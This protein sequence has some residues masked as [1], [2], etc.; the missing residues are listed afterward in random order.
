MKLYYHPLSGYSMKA[1]LALNETD[2][3]FEREIINLMDPESRKSFREVYPLGKVP[4]L[5]LD[6]GHQ[7]PESSIIV[8]WIDQK[9]KTDLIPQDPDLARQA[10]FFDRMSD[11][12]LNNQVGTIFFDTMRPENERNP[13]AVAQAKETLSYLYKKYDKALE[14]KDYLVG[15]F[16]IADLSTFSGLFWAQKVFPYSEYSNLS[17]YFNR[18]M[19]RPGTQKLMTEVGP[20]LEQWE[21]NTK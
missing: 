6:D 20:A 13:E 12:Y 4:F 17:I 9:Y 3:T 14:G 15:P 8:E 16:S 1:L 2:A 21:K 10:R 7:I 18:L 19:D 5:L 11:L